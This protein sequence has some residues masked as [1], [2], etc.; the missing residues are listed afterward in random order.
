MSLN[1]DTH[2]TSSFLPSFHSCSSDLS[3]SASSFPSITPS[4]CLCFP[5]FHYLLISTF[6]FSFPF[7]HPSSLFIFLIFSFH[8]SYFPSLPPMFLSYLVDLFL[9]PPTFIPFFLLSDLS[10]SSFSSLPLTEMKAESLRIWAI[11]TKALLNCCGQRS[12][13]AE[14]LKRSYTSLRPSESWT[15]TLPRLLTDY[16]S[17]VMSITLTVPCV[18]AAAVCSKNALHII[19]NC[20]RFHFPQSE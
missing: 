15:K 1:T 11:R 6:D 2:T 14:W 20:H 16:T 3:F 19:W 18:V 8:N 5:V 17:D 10:T 7:L 12:V 9:T 4:F 13:T